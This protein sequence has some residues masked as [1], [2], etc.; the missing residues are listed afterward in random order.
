MIIVNIIGGLGNQMFQYASGVALAAATDQTVGY[1]TDIFQQQSTHNGFELDRVFGLDLS[2][3]SAADLRREIG[4]LRALPTVRR[5]A[6]KFAVP[7]LLLGPR[8]R[9]E[10]GFAFDGGIAAQLQNGGY[11][12]GYWQSEAYFASVEAEI[13]AALTFRNIEGLTLPGPARHNV[14]LHVRRGDYLNAGSVHAACDA[15][16]YRRALDELNLPPEETR[17]YLFSDDPDWAR[18][19]LASLHPNI[20]VME[21]HMG[22]D[23]YKD[24]YLMSLCDHHII[25]NSSFSWWG[26][27]LNPSSSKRVIAPKTWFTDP[28]LDDR[29]IVPAS[30]ER[31]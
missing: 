28:A 30:W 5:A 26:A 31:L 4:P 9:I 27:W 23:S 14:S 2:I 3:V 24:M 10:R 6:V 13:R 8:F 19:E 25:A 11:L 15:S 20:W 29:S 1:A 18:Y 22:A 21:G 12:H 17:L 7:Q 16:Y